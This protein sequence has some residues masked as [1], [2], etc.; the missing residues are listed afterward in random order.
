MSTTP[1]LDTQQKAYTVSEA[2]ATLRISPWLVREACRRGELRS[3]RIGKRIIIP[4]QA[5]DHFLAGPTEHDDANA[6]ETRAEQSRSL[7]MAP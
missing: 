7:P 5:I 1:Q 4:R 2:A 6:P 3:K